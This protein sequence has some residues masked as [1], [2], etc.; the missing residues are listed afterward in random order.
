MSWSNHS[1]LKMLLSLTVVFSQ[2]TVYKLVVEGGPDQSLV[3]L[4]AVSM[5]Q[6][7]QYVP[8]SHEQSIVVIFG[9]LES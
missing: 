2:A 4:N 7:H 5:M 8:R 9:V 6:L 3:T 1:R